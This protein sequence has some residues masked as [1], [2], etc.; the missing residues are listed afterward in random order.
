M[1]AKSCVPIRLAIVIAGLALSVFAQAQKNVIQPGDHIIASSP[2]SP[3]SEGV[4]NAIDGTQSKYLNFDSGRDGKD[5]FHFSPSGFAVTPSVGVTQII[6]V[7]LQSANDSPGR[8]PKGITVEGSNDDT[9]ADFNSGTWELIYSNDAIPAWTDLFPGGGNADRFKVQTFYF[10]NHKAYKHYRWITTATQGHDNSM[11]IAEVQLLGRVL[12]SN[13]IQPGDPILASSPNSPGSEGV[14]NAIDGTQSKYLNFDS[15][16][17]GK[18]E[19]HFSPSGFVVTPSL[20]ETLVTGIS[21]LSANDSPGRDPKGITVEGTDDDTATFTS[22]NW[23][24]IYVNTNITAWT[25]LFPGGGN[26]DRFKTQTFLFDNFTPY[27][28]YR[29]TVTATQGHDN[30]M[31]IAEVSLLGT[32]APKNVIQPGDKIF[33][34]SPNSPGSEGVA[35]VIDGTQSKYLNFDSGRDGKD[36]F[37]F[38][39]SG[40]AVSPSVGDTTIIGVAMESA[41]DSPGRDPKAI[42]I[43]GS[44]DDT[45]TAF[46]SGT[47][48]TIYV[49]TNIIAWTDLFPGGGNADR[50]KT[51]EFF[52]PN[53]KSYKHYRWTVTATQGHD[54]SMQIAE[55]QLLAVSD[56]ADCK[57]ASFLAQPENTPVL[58]GQPATFYVTVNG[59]WPLQWYRGTNIIQGATGTS[60][61]TPPVTSA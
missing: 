27:K 3:G 47:W 60:Y 6:G 18:D 45:L 39:P 32:G 49:N 28:R 9:L 13:V 25:E 56:S 11:Q 29:W 59:P 48:E 30:S 55:V 52:F 61:T 23:E 38:S 36:E 24:L 4:A 17:D 10:T 51:Q 16:R 8:D 19:F 12:P 35:N 37:H 54:N 34:S 1:H 5:E 42:T 41:N 57:K 33:A 15:G 26:A 44:N 40:F 22:G 43:E 2:N 58:S 7:S 20:G 53:V 14:A 50:F 46:N 21:L 31:Q